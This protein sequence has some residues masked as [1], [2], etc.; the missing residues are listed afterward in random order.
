MKAARH[1]SAVNEPL[2]LDVNTEKVRN[3]Y[4]K[5]PVNTV[6]TMLYLLNFKPSNHRENTETKDKKEEG[7]KNIRVDT[8]Q[9]TE[10]F[11]P[12]TF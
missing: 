2:L 7:G 12:L 3:R 4:L 6:K 9:N 8:K 11:K 1:C 10:V 5:L